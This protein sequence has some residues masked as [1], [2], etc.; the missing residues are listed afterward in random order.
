MRRAGNGGFDHRTVGTPVTDWAPVLS[1]LPTIDL[2]PPHV[3]VIVLAAHPDDETLGAGALIAAASDQGNSITVIVASLGE[4][5]H[6]RSPTHTA[7]KL[8]QIRTSELTEAVGRLA[9]EAGLRTLGLPDGALSTCVPAIQRA[10][11]EALPAG[12]AWVIAP[13]EGD[14]HPDH[15]A[16]SR[17]T[18]RA[19]GDR[20]DVVLWEY[21]IW[22]F[23]WA[24]LGARDLPD[25]QRLDVSEA[26]AR[27]RSAALACYRSQTQP[28]SEQDGDETIVQPGFA[29][30]FDRS[31]DVLLDPK[32]IAGDAS[33]FDDLYAESDDPWDLGGLWYEQRKR[34]LLLASL[35][36]SQFVR[37]FEP[38]CAG[39]LLTAE[40][41]N[42]C[43]ELIAVDSSDRA[44]EVC[45][46]RLGG[47]PGVTTARMSIPSEWAP[48]ALDLIILSEVGYYVADLNHLADRVASSLAQDAVVVL[49]HW[50]HPVL[51]HLHSA[52]TVHQVIAAVPGLH[53]VVEHREADFLLD[54]LAT[55]ETSVARQEGLVQ[56]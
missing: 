46:Q 56:P 48:G 16:C 23:H 28:L 33:Y 43:Q 18:R 53:L 44:V 25:L 55:R 32:G 29:A 41:A 30:H 15:A 34:A 12:P 7:V 24:T 39:G 52:E 10:L 26:A 49:C 51:E 6:P 54:V 11:Q 5:S 21:P 1:G 2:P 50:R 9:P 8:R 14:R 27:R 22:A 38:G 37:A 4:A 45:R 31:F 35:P 17:A 36:R 20:P 47:R 19:I 42:R 13:W 3:P 40:L